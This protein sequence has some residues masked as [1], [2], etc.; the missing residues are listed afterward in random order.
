[1]EWHAGN[2]LSQTVFTLLF[3][4]HLDDFNPDL[5]PRGS[6]SN[7]DHS[8]PQELITLVLRSGVVGLIKSCDLAW[9]EMSHGAINDVR[10]IPGVMSRP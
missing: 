8:R 6:N 2:T 9:R 3:I 1:M 7:T 5:I 10:I 4:H